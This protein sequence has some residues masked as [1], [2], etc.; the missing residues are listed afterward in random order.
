MTERRNGKDRRV[1]PKITADPEEREGD[2]RVNSI[3]Q[4][5]HIPLTL[6]TEVSGRE[7]IATL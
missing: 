1:N 4:G 6:S 5:L 3:I 7:N 2:R